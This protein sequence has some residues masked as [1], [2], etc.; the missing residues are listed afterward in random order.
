MVEFAGITLDSAADAIADIAAG[1]P[2]IVFDDKL[3]ENEGD[4]VFAADH[5]TESLLTFTIRFTSGYICAALAAEDCDRLDLPPMRE[6]NQCPRGTAYAMPVDARLGVSTGISAADRARTIR[7][8][9]AA[10]SVQGDFTRPGHVVPLRAVPGGVLRRQG[11]TE[12][13]L[14]LVRLAGRR[15]AA[16]LCELVNDDGTMQRLP[17]LRRF[18]DRHSLR[19]ISVA[20]LAEYR[21]SIGDHATEPSVAMV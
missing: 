11:H 18:A 5:A 10:E 7:L 1:R 20:A 17:D 3:R 9:A 8:L 19:L 16:V 12:A 14:D 21:I 6:V 4:L 15:P 2:A 13:A